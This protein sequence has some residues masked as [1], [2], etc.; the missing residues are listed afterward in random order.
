MRIYS[1]THNILYIKY[2]QGS[3]KVSCSS[4][5]SLNI[6]YVE[7]KLIIPPGV[8]SKWTRTKQHWALGTS[9]EKW[10]P[11][12]YKM[13]KYITSQYNVIFILRWQ[14]N[15]EMVYLTPTSKCNAQLVKFWGASLY[16]KF[17]KGKRHFYNRRTDRF[18]IRYLNW[19]KNKF[20]NIFKFFRI[21]Y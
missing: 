3:T 9:T 8:E 7:S 5:I 15:C 17:C 1:N 18:E 4:L 19:G 11:N 14:H 6:R 10:I 21:F 16:Y 20:I 13:A 2:G 12:T